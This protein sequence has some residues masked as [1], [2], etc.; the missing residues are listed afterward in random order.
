MARVLLALI[1]VAILIIGVYLVL[2]KPKDPLNQQAEIRRLRR[3]VSKDR[4]VLL[5]IRGDC[6]TYGNENPL[7]G[8]ILHTIDNHINEQEEI[9]P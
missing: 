8:V 4:K 1:F 6:S 9:E 7:A 2:R 3:Q 5:S